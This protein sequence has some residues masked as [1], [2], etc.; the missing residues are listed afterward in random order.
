MASLHMRWRLVINKSI[1]ESK[2]LCSK[3]GAEAN[4]LG[5]LSYPTNG[6]DPEIAATGDGEDQIDDEEITRMHIVKDHG[7]VS[8]KRQKD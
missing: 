2:K 1:F 5:P 6:Y 7:L 4:D 8:S 3:Q